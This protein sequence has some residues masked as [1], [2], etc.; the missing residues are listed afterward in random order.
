VEDEIL[1]TIK[2]YNDI[3][4]KYLEVNQSIAPIKDTLDLFIK[5]IDGVEI[6]DVGCGHGRDA[7]YLSEAGFDV[8]GID[9]SFKLLEIARRN[10]VKL[11]FCMLDMRKLSFLDDSF[12]GVWA[13]AS[14]LHIPKKEAE[15]T[16]RELH[17]VLRPRGLIYASLKEGKGESFVKSQEYWDKERFYAFYSMKELRRLFECSGFEVIEDLTEKANGRSA[18]WINIFARAG[19]RPPETHPHRLNVGRCLIS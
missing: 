12:D 13:C 7:K 18:T 6:L 9:L 11:G 2:T 1:R 14:L 4:E 3:A 16:L 19:R 10:A 8:V 17:R 15:T 5:N